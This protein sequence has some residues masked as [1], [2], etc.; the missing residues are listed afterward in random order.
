[1]LTNPL[2]DSCV[3]FPNLVFPIRNV[4]CFCFESLKFRKLS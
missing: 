4:K 1:M 3:I 2:I